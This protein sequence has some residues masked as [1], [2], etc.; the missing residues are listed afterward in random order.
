MIYFTNFI[1]DRIY[2]PIVSYEIFKHNTTMIIYNDTSFSQEKRF[3]I[4]CK[5]Y[6][7][8]LLVYF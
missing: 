8:Q 4:T 7:E 5:L 1:F 2:F 3:F 6:Y